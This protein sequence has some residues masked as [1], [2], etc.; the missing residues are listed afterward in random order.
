MTGKA[1]SGPPAVGVEADPPKA[2]VPHD[3]KALALPGSGQLHRLTILS[4][5]RQIENAS[6]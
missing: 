1:D 5:S 2:E 3:K 4:H 6:A